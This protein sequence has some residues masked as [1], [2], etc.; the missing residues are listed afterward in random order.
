[1]PSHK[2]LSQE[3]PRKKTLRAASRDSKFQVCQ[4]WEFKMRGGFQ[5]LVA[6]QGTAVANSGFLVAGWRIIVQVGL[7]LLYSIQDELDDMETFPSSA[8]ESN[9][10]GEGCS[11]KLKFWL[12]LQ[13]PRCVALSFLRKFAQ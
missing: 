8:C 13:H 10:L 6:G 9:S 11:G 1:M 12:C 5:G 7:A 4:H 2:K 3:D